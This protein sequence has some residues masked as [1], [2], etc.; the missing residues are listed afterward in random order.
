[1]HVDNVSAVSGVP[2]MTEKGGL[3]FNGLPQVKH[4]AMMATWSKA[5]YFRHFGRVTRPAPDSTKANAR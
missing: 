3:T 5:N 4:I 2:A 1:V